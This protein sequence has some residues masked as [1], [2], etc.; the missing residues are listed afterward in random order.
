M[1]TT[2]SFPKDQIKVLLLENIAATAV[3]NFKAEGFQVELLKTDN[4]LS[5]ALP[6]L[7]DLGITPTP[8]EAV[9]PTYL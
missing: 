1:T 8:L 3:D 4:V 2:T 7:A 9:L 5:D 6:G